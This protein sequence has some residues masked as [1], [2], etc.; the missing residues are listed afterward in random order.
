MGRI[1]RKRFW[2]GLGTVSLVGTAVLVLT[3]ASAASG[4]VGPP[5][6]TKVAPYKGAFTAYQST[7]ASQCAK[8]SYS[9]P[10][11]FSFATGKGSFGAGTA[12]A[13]ICGKSFAGVGQYFEAGL[14][15]QLTVA[16]SLALPTGSHHVK[17]NWNLAWNVTGKNSFTSCPAAKPFANYY[18]YVSS[19]FAYWDNYSGV[20]AVCTSEIFAEVLLFEAYITDLTNGSN[21]LASICSSTF[22]FQQLA[23]NSTYTT[24]ESGYEFYND[25]T[26]SSSS[27][28]SYSAGT[29]SLNYTHFGPTTMN[30]VGGMAL[31]LYINGTFNR[32]HHYAMIIEALG[33]AFADLEGWNAASSTINWNMAGPSNGMD[34]SSV[35]IA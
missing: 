22:C 5:T 32:A 7:Q 35:V 20:E 17:A 23:F 2:T 29:F 3:L 18:S 28:Y 21:F 6:V 9:K 31:P 27:G 12:S 26:W 13:H 14:S 10:V 11:G 30:F 1:V 25:T 4:A 34:L 24:N 8:A 19:T 15:P 33:D 16:V